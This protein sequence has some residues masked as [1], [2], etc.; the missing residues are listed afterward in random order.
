MLKIVQV[1]PDPSK[2]AAILLNPTGY[3]VGTHFAI[4]FRDDIWEFYQ[5]HTVAYY[6]KTPTDARIKVYTNDPLPEGALSYYS[7]EFVETIEQE[8]YDLHDAGEL[9]VYQALTGMLFFF[10]DVYG[11]FLSP[12]FVPPPPTLMIGDFVSFGRVKDC[13]TLREAVAYI[14]LRRGME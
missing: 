14:I 12:V 10:G 4:G 7:C 9:N 11:A 6:K 1:N 8:L 13:F 3:F 5:S 2:S